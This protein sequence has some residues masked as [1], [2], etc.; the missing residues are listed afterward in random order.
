METGD[1]IDG[2][3]AAL[4][5]GVPGER[6]LLTSDNVNPQIM[7]ELGKK[8]I[9]LK[10]PFL[11]IPHWTLYLIG[12]LAEVLY[13]FKPKKPKLNRQIARLAKLKFYYSHDKAS[14]ELGYNPKPLG[15]VVSRILSAVNR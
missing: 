12:A 15:D 5:R 11:K 2:I 7:F 8:Y 9:G 3:I 1:V 10:R 6:Y 13:V 14:N 4:E